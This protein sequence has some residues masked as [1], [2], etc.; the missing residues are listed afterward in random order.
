MRLVEKPADFAN[1]LASAQR[2]AQ[3][4]FGDP[5]CLIEKFIQN[6]R[7]IEMQVMG[8]EHGNVIHLFERDCSMQRRHQKVIE[9]APAPDMPDDVR[10]AMGAAA[11]AAAKAVSYQGAGTV[12]FIVDGSGPLRPDGFWFM[13]MNTRLQVEHPVTEEI[14]GFDLVAMQIAVA[15]GQ[16][17]P[18]TQDQITATGHAFEV[19]L[20]AEDPSNGFLPATGTLDILDFPTADN[21]VRVDTGV[22]QGDVISP[23]Y[24]PM[25]AKLIVTGPNRNAALLKMSKAL[26]ELVVHG[27]VTNRAFLSALV[28]D[29][30]FAAGRVDTGLIDRK[31]AD[32]TA[33]PDPTANILALAALAAVRPADAEDPFAN[34]RLWGAARQAV[35]F[36][37]DPN[38]SI[39]VETT[40]SETKV[41]TPLGEVTFSAVWQNGP[42]LLVEENGVKSR[43]IVHKTGHG[44]LVQTEGHDRFFKFFD[45]SA[46]AS[47]GKAGALTA[48]MPGNVIA[49]V[50]KAGDSVS[51]GDR[52]LVME[53]MKME[54]AI[55]AAQDGVIGEMLVSEGD[56]VEQGALLVRMQEDE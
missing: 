8:D 1:A 15:E 39:F 41:T 42:E 24:D 16:A 35:T 50:A 6:P 38:I 2:E 4:S 11:V 31:G 28:I 51:E 33:R 18:V 53:A 10:Q 29:A 36:E 12:E 40:A 13:E 19:R 14:T 26:E 37:G 20:Y 3:S 22:R 34:F 7:H 48:P 54:H 56:Q 21:G 30:D 44:V 5:A 17:L 49:V 23:H 9:E 46:S 25:I 27:C 52:L 32:L 43:A 55:T 47:S 45:P